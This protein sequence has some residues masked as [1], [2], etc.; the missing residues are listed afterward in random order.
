MQLDM[1]S[2]SLTGE[3]GNQMENQEPKKPRKP[4]QKKAPLEQTNEKPNLPSFNC[5]KCDH[6][7][8]ILIEQ[9]H[10]YDHVMECPECFDRMTDH[11]FSRFVQLGVA[12]NTSFVRQAVKYIDEFMHIKLAEGGEVEE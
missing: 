7:I 5:P 4:R 9:D 10:I 1:A 3:R 6:E 2:T 11:V 8:F 12:M